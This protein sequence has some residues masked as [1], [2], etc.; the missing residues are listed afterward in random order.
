MLVDIQLSIHTSDIR[1]RTSN[2]G[3]HT[4]T[5]DYLLVH[6]SDIRIHTSTCENLGVH[7]SDLRVHTSNIWIHTSN[8]RIHT[9]AHGNIQVTYEYIGVTYDGRRVI[10][11]KCIYTD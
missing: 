6:T 10:N 4:S 2:I 3:I 5:Y 8:I 1:V 11:M 9:D 7:T